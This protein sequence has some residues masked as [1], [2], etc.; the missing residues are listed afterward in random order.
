[1][2]WVVGSAAC[3]L[4]AALVALLRPRR[5]GIP[6]KLQA[7]LT[8]AGGAS[9][10]VACIAPLHGSVEV[11]QAT[12]PLSFGPLALRLDPLSAVFLVP[13]AVIGSLAAFYAQGYARLGHGVPSSRPSMV[14]FPLLLVAMTM[15]AVA[16]NTVLL[17]IAWELMTLTSWSLL[18]AH[19]ERREVRRAGLSYLI[20][21]H[22]SAAALLLLF[23][24]LS[25][26]P[27][28]WAIPIQPGPLRSTTLWLALLL[29]WVG[30]GTKAAVA[31]LHVWLP[32]A[33]GAAPS[34]VS[35]LMSGVLITM[36]F[37][38]LLRF[39]PALAPLP[40]SALLAWIGLGALGTC[41]G[42]LMALS[43]RDVKR[44]LAYST[45]ENAGLVTLASGA[46]LLSS[47]H[48]HPALAALAWGAA[49]LHLWNHAVAKSLVFLAAG[50]MG[51]IVGSLDLEQ[52][53][54]LL[55]R[56]PLLGTALLVGTASLVAL[57][58]THGFAGEW[59]LFLGL[60]RGAQE[61]VGLPRLAMVLSVVATAFAAG[62]ALAC[63]VRLAG[64]GLLGHPRSR[65]AADAAWPLSP[66]L[67]VPVVTLAAS[68][69]A[70]VPI[71]GPL[72]A[73][74]GPAVEQLAPG[75]SFQPVERMAAPLPW[76]AILPLA[77][78]V[79]V[80]MG[81]LWLHRRRP[82][83]WSVTWD[84]GIS[85]PTATMQYTASSL[86]APV[87]KVLQPALRTTF[88]WAP[89]RGLWPSALA[90]ESRTP[91]RA[92]AELYRPAFARLS[93]LLGLLARLQ[94]GRVVTYVR[95]VG[96]AL[97]VLLAWLFLPEPWR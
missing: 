4:V 17:L 13:V 66:W 69:F 68:C 16:A 62:A 64:V 26:S 71:L 95:Y 87:T 59:L 49:L 7:I 48:G 82:V 24:L 90:W 44:I 77:S 29:C 55:R 86:A 51:R 97:L 67:A 33:H 20:A 34:H 70:L 39:V 21:G 94:E 36:G 85:R 1:V 42:I 37:Y 96:L 2:S 28:G 72:L 81:R 31:P 5:G 38:G 88:R 43:Q 58:G 54:G 73:L 32:D 22:V 41:G 91:E 10:M 47:A 50:A 75:A 53:G 19:H 30:F 8:L 63:F 25:Q 3:W 57:P 35:A 78:V 40:P 80:A 65:A 18:T 74:L 27:S 83:R 92:L 12:W 93:R 15:V 52:W 60:F 76:L 61:M 14:A 9:L 84:C 11:R 89:P 6:E 79:L 46:A 56:L 45:I 23:A